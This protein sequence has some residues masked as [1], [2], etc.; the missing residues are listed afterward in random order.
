MMKILEMR[1]DAQNQMIFSRN[2][3]IDD[4][5]IIKNR[6]AKLENIHRYGC[7]TCNKR[8]LTF[9]ALN[10]HRVSHKKSK[11]TTGSIPYHPYVHNT[12]INPSRFIDN[13]GCNLDISLGSSFSGIGSSLMPLSSD[14]DIAVKKEKVNACS[15]CGIKF[16]SDQ[17]LGGH[18]RRHRIVVQPIIRNSPQ[19]TQPSCHFPFDLNNFLHHSKKVILLNLRLTHRNRRHLLHLHLHVLPIFHL[20]IIL[21]TTT[22]QWICQLFSELIVS[23]YYNDY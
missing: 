17:V 21:N 22:T 19:S 16:V 5:S 15:V 11:T 3:A 6:K 8:I 13:E 23:H 12:F 2:E 14:C 7:E 10:G 20:M 1:G 9:Q 4:D 18:M